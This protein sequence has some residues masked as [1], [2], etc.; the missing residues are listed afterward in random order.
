MKATSLTVIAGAKFLAS[1]SE[2]CTMKSR[3][4]RFNVICDASMPITD[5]KIWV[6]SFIPQILEGDYTNEG[7]G[8]YI[9]WSI[10]GAH[11]GRCDPGRDKYS[12]NWYTCGV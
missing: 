2:K 1:D 3:D 12:G 8:E 11:V 6:A 4:F 10:N 5:E 9:D 7:G